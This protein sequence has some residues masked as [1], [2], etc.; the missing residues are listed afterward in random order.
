MSHNPIIFVITVFVQFDIEE[1]R[2]LWSRDSKLN[3]LI[4][5]RNEGF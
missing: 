2:V 5:R 4:G 3:I 1:R